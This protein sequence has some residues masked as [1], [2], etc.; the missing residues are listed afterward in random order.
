MNANKDGPVLTEPEYRDEKGSDT[1]PNPPLKLED[2]EQS[3]SMIDIDPVT[4]AKLL[5]KLDIRIV[6]MICWIYLMNF[7]DRGAYG[8]L[9]L[10]SRL[11][12]SRS[13]HRQCSSLQDGGG[14]WHG[15]R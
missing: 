8:M 7:M 4:E 9:I 3:A 1:S 5:R 14:S 2:V 10:R 12:D 6:P 11:T 15:P 13:Q